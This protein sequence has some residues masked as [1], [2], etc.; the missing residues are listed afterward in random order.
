[1]LMLS[2]E[3]PAMVGMA[4]PYS[5]TPVGDISVTALCMLLF[6]LLMQTHI[7]KDR[8][9]YL[10][11][12]LLAASVA[13]SYSNILYEVFLN[14]G[15]VQPIPVYIFRILHHAS[16]LLILYL[17]IR[18]L[19]EP[20][21]IQGDAQNRYKWLSFGFLAASVLIDVL[22]TI[23]HF[24]YYID[25]DGTVHNIFNVYFIMHTLFTITVFYLIIRYRGR[26]IRPVFWGLLSSH[27]VLLIIMA[28]Q[29]CMRQMSFT[30][31][32]YFMPVM[33][34]FFMFHSNPFDL[35]TGAASES[36]FY[37][38]VRNALEKNK[39]EMILSC[40]I[41]NFSRA[42]MSSKKLKYEYY[43]FFRQHVRK[44]VVYQ[45][46]DR[47]VLVIPKSEDVQQ[48]IDK[49]LVSFQKSHK[50]FEMDYK[51]VMLET[52]PGIQKATDYIHI[53]EGAER[54]MAFNTV[55]WIDEKDLEDFYNS[56]YILSELEDIVQCRDLDDP[57]VLVYCQPVYNITTRTY[58]TAEALMRPKLPKIGM[59]FP[60]QF[61]PLAE[62]HGHI[63][64]LSMIILNKTCGAIRT[65]MEDE[66]EINR[67]S[68]NFSALDIRYETFCREVQMI[69]D[70]NQIPYEKIAIEITES[71][72]D[73]D[74]QLMKTKVE[75]LQ[76]LGIKF[77]L[78]DF[79]TGYSN[80][81]RIM[82]IPFDIIKF[83]R[84]MTIESAKSETSFYMVSTF[85]NMFSKLHY[86]VLFEGI[87]DANDEE[88][89]VKM[90][91]RYLQGY[92]YSKPIPIEEL[93][94]FLPK[95]S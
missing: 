27:V 25:G 15:T 88:N 38:A 29:G 62:Q 41:L 66:Y 65:L 94:R 3:M 52:G 57:R 36:Y 54:R 22:G 14:A 21:W 59:V 95:A 2:H 8:K 85:A 76:K 67:I 35:N 18:Y 44:G 20:L 46:G 86:S 70:R 34:I 10:L 42:I 78:D 68:V 1:M 51:I 50:R 11:V 73:A 74:F 47:L 69:I 58:D 19:Q 31:V 61:I 16:L 17:N 90:S 40:N 87:E 92:K 28:M 4:N 13:C 91:A 56:S 12:L 53:I 32:A 89:C 26:V 43:M 45:I 81:E 23:F 83:D 71:R 84:S 37:N 48:A 39:S 7:H 72:S 60:D 64:M 77:Y 82:E 80:F 9:F 30:G 75:E 5:Y 49:M 93:S 63:H 55:H 33:A 24:T 6:V 79:G